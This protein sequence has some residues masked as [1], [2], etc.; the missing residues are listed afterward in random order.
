MSVP[1]K[2]HP[3]AD[4]FPLMGEEELSELAADIKAHGLLEPVWLYADPERG[5]VV[6]D[7][8]NRVAACNRAGVEVRT[9]NYEGSDPIQFALSLN[10]KRRHLNAG[11]KAFLALEVERLYRVEGKARQVEAGR[12]YGNGKHVAELPQAKA[13][14]AA[15]K[16]RDKAAKVT[17]AS[18]RAVSQAKR[19]TEAA[20]DLAEKVKAGSLALDRAE[21]IVRDREAEQRHILEAQREAA[22][23]KVAPTVDLRLGDFREVLADVRN[24]DAIITDPPYPHEFIPLLADLRD[25][26]D[27]A[28]KPDGVLVVLM[29]QTY[30]PEVYRLLEGGRPYRWTGCYLTPGAGYASMAR[31]C[32]SNWK[33][34]LVYGGGPRFADLVKTEATDADAKNH[35]KWG[36]DYGA[37]HELVRRFT[38]AGQTIA[39]PFMGAGTTLLAGKAQGRNVIG[40]EIDPE[41]YA[42]A[43]RRL[44]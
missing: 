38:T 12:E 40:A 13:Q 15:P 30:L 37:F 6:L 27:T 44:A 22:I 10:E 17:G 33:P 34:L 4:L 3:A 9:R 36:Q 8:R 43:A 39:D 28:L 19:V 2:A 11:Q 21:R 24:L 35:H 25:W 23:L 29:G 16:S 41:H 42:T 26:A 20:P 7:G 14:K 5:T 1:T 31:R 32:Q 18:G